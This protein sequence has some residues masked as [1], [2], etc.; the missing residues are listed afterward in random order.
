[1]KRKTGK[2][3]AAIRGIL[4]PV[5][6]AGSFPA[7]AEDLWDV[8]QLALK[9]DSL[10]QAARENYEAVRIN[11]PLARTGFK[12]TVN[13]T[14]TLGKQRSDARG[15]TTTGDNHQVSVRIDLPL[16]NQATRI[17]ISQA[18]L[19]VQNALLQFDIARDSL[20][21][22]VAERYF[23]LLA[24][25]DAKEVARL[26][27]IA[28]KRQMDLARERLEV[29]LGTRTDLFDARAR[30]QQADADLIASDI[31]ISNARQALIEMVDVT[32]KTISELAENSPLDPPDPDD[33]THWVDRAQTGNL[34][35]KSEEMNLLLA[36]QE[37][38]R[39]RARR[40]PTVNFEAMQ[41]WADNGSGP[42][43]DDITSTSLGVTL[44]LPLY[45][46]GSVELGIRQAGLRR[47]TAEQNLEAARRKA[48]SAATSAFLA[49]TSGI[50]QVTALAEAI[51]AGENALQAKEEGF[52]AG[53]TTNLDVL[54]AQRDLS[55]SR[56]N[57]LRARYNYILSL[58]RLEQAVGDL[59]DED[60][61]F[62]ND[63]LTDRNTAQ[64]RDDLFPEFPYTRPLG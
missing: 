59:G 40:S 9:N 62:I 33:V 24:A 60:I 27:K 5:A 39:Q 49:V 38:D 48:T 30:F 12:P 31:E 52:S 36:G 44:N 25:R 10:Y 55:L 3:I 8:Y 16:I 58:L 6:L 35:V 50:S 26:Q 28:I 20:T 47:N 14:G 34:Q 18:E 61:R 13:G 15:P 4:L 43:G 29:G 11:L 17:R 63:W 1:M 32:P 45:L 7:G 22:R 56:T 46:G 42:G 37:V 64:R 19:E 57:Y 51:V 41:R 2:L 23:N 54:D 21:L 53:L